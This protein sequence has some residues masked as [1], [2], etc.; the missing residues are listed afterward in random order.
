M[1]E[2]DGEPPP[3][4]DPGPSPGDVG[5]LIVAAND[6]DLR[7]DVTDQMPEL[8][9]RPCEEAINERSLKAEIDEATSGLVELVVTPSSDYTGPR[10]VLSSNP[11]SSGPDTGSDTFGLSHWEAEKLKQLRKPREEVPLESL[12]LSPDDQRRIKKLKSC[13]LALE[14]IIEEYLQS[15]D[16]LACEK[17]YQETGKGNEI[18]PESKDPEFS[19]SA[20]QWIK[21][22]AFTS[23]TQKLFNFH[24]DRLKPILNFE[25]SSEKQEQFEG[26]QEIWNTIVQACKLNLELQRNSDIAARKTCELYDLKPHEEVTATTRQ[27]SKKLYAVISSA[28]TQIREAV[29]KLSYLE[30]YHSYYEVTKKLDHLIMMM[31]PS[32]PLREEPD[33]KITDEGTSDEFLASLVAQQLRSTPRQ[34]NIYKA[35]TKTRAC[36]LRV[37]SGLS[38]YYS[39]S[40]NQPDWDLMA[41]LWYDALKARD[42]QYST[43]ILETIAL[44]R[45]DLRNNKRSC[46]SS[47]IL[48]AAAAP[49]ANLATRK[50]LLQAQQGKAKQGLQ[51]TQTVPKGT[52]AKKAVKAELNTSEGTKEPVKLQDH[53]IEE[54]QNFLNDND[55][56]DA[57]KQIKQM[58]SAAIEASL[59]LPDQELKILRDLSSV[60]REAEVK[61][62]LKRMVHFDYQVTSAAT[63]EACNLPDQLKQGRT[64]ASVPTYHKLD[65]SKGPFRKALPQIVFNV[66]R[67]YRHPPSSSEDKKWTEYKCPHSQHQ[68]GESWVDAQ[69]AIHPT[70]SAMI[71]IG[72][73]NA[74]QKNPVFLINEEDV[75]EWMNELFYSTDPSTG[76]RTLVPETFLDPDIFKANF[77]T[78]SKEGIHDLQVR[79]TGSSSY[80]CTKHYHE[81]KYWEDLLMP[82]TIQT[83]Q[84]AQSAKAC[85]FDQ[86]V[87]E[88]SANS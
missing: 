41:H 69:G 75:F 40:G 19:L 23:V 42:T 57:E 47:K 1:D 14:S 36:I 8:G 79:S 83:C 6:S 5:N 2:G 54:L 33:T 11:N 86:L 76:K 43:T 68:W 31:S 18:E 77:K 67:S 34:L 45:Q 70:F 56:S 87:A 10:P 64:P 27:Y 50:P 59:A 55:P 20:I 48:Q 4:H 16:A 7:S 9:H 65:D 26:F 73:P 80:M 82:I 28:L 49:A 37:L 22:L 24:F 53:E 62:N 12:G 60:P 25:D 88:K 15:D 51:P 52:K 38:L 30:R 17:A 44:A 63:K 81:K 46:A 85:K 58:V 84:L 71:F 78:V 39:R 61:K 32:E 21:S 74:V 29:A 3:L 66:L 13:R 72:Q 35:T